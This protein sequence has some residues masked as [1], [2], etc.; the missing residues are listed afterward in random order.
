M[1]VIDKILSEWSYRC[2]DGIVDM[3]NPNKVSIL[4]EILIEYKIKL[5]E[6]QTVNEFESLILKKYIAPNQ[7]I[8]GLKILYESIVKSNNASELF[9]LIE[10]SGGKTLQTGE[11]NITDKL[12]KELFNLISK[13]VDI[14]NGNPSELWFAIIYNFTSKLRLFGF[15][16]ITGVLHFYIIPNII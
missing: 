1:N 8:S 16:N 6:I 3:N 14:P 13:T 2:H 12:E 9:S 7:K 5:N 15:W 4:S 11:Y 10:K